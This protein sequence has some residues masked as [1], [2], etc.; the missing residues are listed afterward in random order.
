MFHIVLGAFGMQ[1]EWTICVVVSFFRENCV[2]MNC[3]CYKA[4]KLLSHNMNVLE[5]VLKK[6]LIF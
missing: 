1:I 3:S 4:V 5:G 2:I 6:I